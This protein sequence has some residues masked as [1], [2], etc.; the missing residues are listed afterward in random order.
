MSARSTISSSAW[1]LR[2][3]NYQPIA[4][5]TGPTRQG[6]HSE[7]E[8]FLKR[9]VTICSSALIHNVMIKKNRIRFFPKTVESKNLKN[10]HHGLQVPL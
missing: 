5:H 4:M 6:C 10:F 8:D 7:N 2:K 3:L 9:K 1:S